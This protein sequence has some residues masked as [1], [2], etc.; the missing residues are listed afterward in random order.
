[1]Y[2][3]GRDPL[4]DLISAMNAFFNGSGGKVTYGGAQSGTGV[5]GVGGA[6]VITVHSDGKVSSSNGTTTYIGPDGSTV[7]TTV[8]DGNRTQVVKSLDGTTTF[9]TENGGTVVSVIQRPG[10]PDEIII[11]HSDGTVDHSFDGISVS[12]GAGDPLAGAVAENGNTVGA[13]QRPPSRTTTVV[14]PDGTRTTRVEY[15]PGEWV[16]G[17]ATVESF[18]TTWVTTTEYPNGEKVTESFSFS[19]ILNTNVYNWRYSDGSRSTL[20]AYHS[21]ERYLNIWDAQRNLVKTLVWKEGGPTENFIYH[22]LVISLLNYGAAPFDP[23]ITSWDDVPVRPVPHPSPDN[24]AVAAVGG[25]SLRYKLGTSQADVM[26]GSDMLYGLEGDDT[27][28]GGSSADLLNGGTDNDSLIG[29]VG[30]DRLY[31]GSGNDSADGGEGHDTL[32]GGEG[33]RLPERRDRQ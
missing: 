8:V 29:G 3:D 21:G 32:D 24:T 33:G 11:K 6:G 23:R 25:F 14:S 20:T 12:Y 17:G 19:H 31:G 2:A 18:E 4:D 26:S 27:L 15:L 1:M 7:T 10:L 5:G 16:L 28:T 30:D 9:N 22:W 13:V